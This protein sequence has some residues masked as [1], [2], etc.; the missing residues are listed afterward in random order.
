MIQGLAARTSSVI[1]DV[2]DADDESARNRAIDVLASRFRLH[3]LA[4]DRVLGM[5]DGSI[6]VLTREQVETLVAALPR[7]Y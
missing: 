1:L 7:N 4:I 5:P 3:G 2:V 6:R